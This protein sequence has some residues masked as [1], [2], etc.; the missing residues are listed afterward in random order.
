MK[1]NKIKTCWIFKTTVFTNW[2]KYK[3]GSN[4]CFVFITDFQ[5]CIPGLFDTVT[6]LHMGFRSERAAAGLGPSGLNT[7]PSHGNI[8]PNIFYACSNHTMFKL[9]VSI[10]GVC[11]ASAPTCVLRIM[12][13]LTFLKSTDSGH[14]RLGKAA[15]SA[16]GA[17]NTWL[18]SCF[19]SSVTH[20][21]TRLSMLRT[22]TVA[23]DNC[24][25][26]ML[27]HTAKVMDAALNPHVC[28]S[29]RLLTH[30]SVTCDFVYVMLIISYL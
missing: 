12:P 15:R 14:C 7:Q 25:R 10:S 13:S 17:L 29:V 22:G 3:V 8:V 21:A 2:E 9:H 28:R 18:F 26:N 30:T 4:F 20:T 19:C 5:S 27:I 11:A 23:N 6:S 24:K 1:K 16:A